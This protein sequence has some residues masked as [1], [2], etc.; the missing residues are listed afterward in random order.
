[1][2]LRESSSRSSAPNSARGKRDAKDMSMIDLRFYTQN[3]AYAE[4]VNSE[5]VLKIISLFSFYF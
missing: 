3:L 2:I 4:N 5:K 1:M